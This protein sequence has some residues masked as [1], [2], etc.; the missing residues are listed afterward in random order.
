MNS[1]GGCELPNLLVISTYGFA[2]IATNAVAYLFIIFFWRLIPR[3]AHQPQTQPQQE[4]AGRG[5]LHISACHFVVCSN[6]PHRKARSLFAHAAVTTRY[7]A[8]CITVNVQCLTFGSTL[9][10]YCTIMWGAESS[11]ATVA[12]IVNMVNMMRQKRSTTIAANFQ[13]LITS[14]SS[15]AFFIRFVMNCNSRRIIRR[16]RC[17]PELGTAASSMVVG[18]RM[19]VPPKFRPDYTFIG[20]QTWPICSSV[21]LSNISTTLRLNEIKLDL[22]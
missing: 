18:W 4:C 2:N 20:Y 17:V 22:Y 7:A 10:A 19:K 13:S 11:T 1:G 12:M 21:S 16:S 15:S 3:R 9:Y 14:A 5:R 8:Y 6:V